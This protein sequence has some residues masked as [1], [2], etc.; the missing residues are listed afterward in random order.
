MRSDVPAPDDVYGWSVRVDSWLGSREL[1]VGVPLLDGSLT[2][3]AGSD[4]L[5]E[6]DIT[7]PPATD[8]QDWWPRQDADHPLARYGQRLQYTLLAE[9]GRGPVE[10]ALARHQVHDWNRS[11]NGAI[12]VQCEST[13]AAIA[14][15]ELTGPSATVVGTP[16]TAA[17]ML[18]LP[19]GEDVV[20]SLQLVN[21]SAAARAWGESRVEGL[22]EIAASWPA[23]LRLDPWGRV[24]FGAPLPEVPRP[25]LS[26]TDG[27][28]GVLVSVEGIQD[29]RDGVFN[30]V[31]AEGENSDGLRFRRVQ[32]V[33]DGPLAP[34]RYGRVVR[35]ITSDLIDSDAAAMDAARA[36]LAESVALAST[37][38]ISCPPDW[39]VEVDDPVAVT[40]AGETVWG[41]VTGVVA[42]VVAG[43]LMRIDVGVVR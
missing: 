13:M 2:W 24:S 18:L 19:S 8:E 30:T 11:A 16:L 33:L 25:V 6:S 22:R 42:P 17:A 3:A 14:A 9:T 1:A 5:E 10:I 12:A 39:R 21:R 35:R 29:T 7:V 36:G 4:T 43:D 38:R 20:F 27:Q 37:W 31:V 32:E 26:F 15:D 40:Y 41:W 34:A 28:A 23:L